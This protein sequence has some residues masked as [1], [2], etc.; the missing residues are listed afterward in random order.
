MNKAELW[1]VA[2]KGLLIPLVWG[3]AAFLW[4]MALAA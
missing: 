3:L 4:G 2:W 1:E